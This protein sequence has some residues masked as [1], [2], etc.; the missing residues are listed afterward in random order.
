MQWKGRQGCD[1]KAVKLRGCVREGELTCWR[2]QAGGA[3]ALGPPPQQLTSARGGG[4]RSW[5]K[6]ISQCQGGTGYRFASQK[7]RKEIW[8]G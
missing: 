7:A 8:T 4:K 1:R 6:R 2:E 5:E 3:P